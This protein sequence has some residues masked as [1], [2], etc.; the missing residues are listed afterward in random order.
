MNPP[1]GM[2]PDFATA[3]SES[4][5]RARGRPGGRLA[6]GDAAARLRSRGYNEVAGNAAPVAAFSRSS[7]ACRVDAR[8]DH[9]PVAVLRKFADL[10]VVGALLVVN[11]VLG[12]LQERGHPARRGAA[13]APAVSARGPAR[14]RLEGRPCPRAGGRGHR[15]PARRG[16]RPGGHEA[17]CRRAARRPVGPHRRIGDVEKGAGDI[18]SSG[19]VVRR[20]E[21]NGVVVLT[22]RGRI[23]GA[24]GTGAAGPPE[25][26]H[27]R[28]SSR[29]SSAGSSSSSA[30]SSPL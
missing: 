3:K 28:R 4:A 1:P 30:C 19:S 21:G 5:V 29:R 22:A 9:D 7:G 6:Q 13:P 10:A 14:C 12:F 24:H 26:A 2:P 11:A 27:P 16:H 8:A 25:A 15:S 20:G 23:S 18:L 17:P